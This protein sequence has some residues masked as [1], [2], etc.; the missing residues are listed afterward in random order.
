MLT[1]FL[2]LRNCPEEVWV[3]IYYCHCLSLAA[4][5]TVFTARKKQSLLQVIM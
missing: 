2:P 3:N 1:A 5:I 4:Y